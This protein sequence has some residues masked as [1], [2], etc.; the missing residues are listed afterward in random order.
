MLE[1]SHIF[2]INGIAKVGEQKK[3][4]HAKLKNKLK[5]LPRRMTENLSDIKR[6]KISPNLFLNAK[7]ISRLNCLLHNS[8]T[9]K[10]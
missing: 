5:F 10:I 7:L 6:K 9:F 4:F 1:T 2:I 8:T 3:S